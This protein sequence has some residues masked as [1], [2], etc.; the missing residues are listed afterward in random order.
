MGESMLANIKPR[1]K[2]LG[3]KLK[4]SKFIARENIGAI[5]RREANPVHIAHALR[6]QLLMSSI[7][8]DAKYV[9]IDGKIFVDPFVPFMPSPYFRKVLENNSVTSLP[10]KPNYAEIA[11]TNKCPCDCF[12]CHVKNTDET[13]L[14]ETAIL[15]AIDD[16]VS[17]D[18]PLLI[19]AGGEPMSRFNSL[20]R[21]VRRASRDLDTRL[22]TSGV[23]ASYERLRQLK[24]AG[25]SG[26]YVSIDHSTPSKHNELRQHPNAFQRACN[27]VASARE[28]GF[29]VSVVCC[30]SVFLVEF[31]A[32]CLLLDFLCQRF[33]GLEVVR[34]DGQQ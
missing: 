15:G 4:M 10:L 12:H 7:L 24:D 23:G 19:F 8:R 6:K 11:I 13:D 27:T 2:Q 28:L 21:F 25:L 31:V 16:I 3:L 9:E 22:F 34:Y 33:S 29:Y 30:V 14:S 32:H 26:L 5:A 20:L 18:F 17:E 1:L